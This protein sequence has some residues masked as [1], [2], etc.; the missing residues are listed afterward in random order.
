ML[1]CKCD[2]CRK[3]LPQP[4]IAVGTFA[5]CERCAP[6]HEEYIK[7]VMQITVESTQG[8]MKSVER[9]RNKFIQEQVNK[10]RVVPIESKSVSG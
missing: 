10:L 7:G 8:Y 9:F 4:K 5:F 1:V 2:T 6:Y 3:D